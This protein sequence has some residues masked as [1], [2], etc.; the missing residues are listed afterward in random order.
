MRSPILWLA[1]MPCMAFR[2]A[3]QTCQPLEICSKTSREF[4][5]RSHDRKQ[6][7]GSDRNGNRGPNTISQNVIHSLS[8]NSGAISNSIYALYC[9]FPATTANVVE[10][11]FVHSLS[12]TSTATT[13]QLVGILPVAGTALIRT[14][15]SVWAWMPPA[16][17]SR[18]DMPFTECSKSP[19][20]TICTTTAFMLAALES[21]Q[22]ALPS[23]L[24]AT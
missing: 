10:R 7:H 16:P 13:S 4:E 17:R 21:L 20:R 18:L 2:T 12:I 22:R 23:D 24:S 14:T 5:R 3:S 8:N 1:A 11:N 6:R 9:S 15:W 19:A